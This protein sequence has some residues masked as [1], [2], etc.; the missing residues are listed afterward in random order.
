MPR[1]LTLAL[2]S[3]SALFAQTSIQSTITGTV[4]DATSAVVEGA[5]VIATRDSTGAVYEAVSSPEGVYLLPRVA[6]GV[7]SVSAEK[8]GF[9]RLIRD[10]I[11]VS[12]NQTAVVDLNLTVG[13][14]AERVQV[15]ADAATVQSQTSEVSLL[16]GRRDVR[17][18]PLNGKDFQ[19]LMFLAPGVGGQRATNT[20]TNNS[21]SGAR[22]GSNNY[23]IDGVSANDER[24]V[25]G[26]PLGASSR[27]LPNVI[28]TEA[29]EEFR[30]ITSNADAT[31]GRG[32]GGQ[33]NGITRSGSNEFHGS[34]YEFL[35]NDALD[36]RDF[37][38]YGPFFDSQ[39]RSVTPPFRQ[40]LFGGTIGGPVV[41][42]K[43]FFFGNYEGFRQRLE[44]SSNVNLP[45]ADLVRL[46]PGQF[47]Q[48]AR[49]Y[50]FE[51][52]L[53]PTSG[54]LPGELRPFGQ[55]DRQAAIAGGF[56]PVLFDANVA[57]GEAATTLTS[58]SSTADFRQNAFLIRTD[59]VFTDKLHVSARYA[60]AT[61]RSDANTAGLPGTGT[62]TPASFHSPMVQTVYTAAPNQVL[63]FRA[64]VMRVASDVDFFGGFPPSVA[65]VGVSPEVGIQVSAAGTTF[66][67][68]SLAP[69]LVRDNQ[70]TPQIAAQHTLSQGRFTLR[71]G[72]DIRHINVNF[73]NNTFPRP[74]WQFAGLVGPN[75]LLGPSSSAAEAVAVS[76]GQTFFG[77]NNGPTTPQRG[78][79]S[80]QQEYFT[81]FDWRVMRNLTLNLGIRY[82]YFG[83]YGEANDALSNLYAEQDGRVVPDINAFT[84][85]RLANTVAPISGDL[86]LY[87]PDRNNWQPR[88]GFAWSPMGRTV[89]RGAYG[90]YVDRIYQLPLSNLA[91]NVPYAIAASAANVSF[92][93]GDLP[94]SPSQRPALFGVDPA[95]RNPYLHRFNAAVE[96]EVF[97]NTT[98]TAAYVGSIGRKLIRTDEPNMAG[99]FPLNLRPEQRFADQRIIANLSSSDYDSLQLTLRRRFAAGLSASVTYTWSSYRDDSST[100]F[101]PA[102]P[103]L[104]NLDASSAAGFQGG[105]RLAPRPVTADYGRSE[106]DAPHVFVAGWVYDLPFGKSRRWGANWNGIVDG[107]LGNWSVSG[108]FQIRS[109]PPFEVT[110][111]Q[112]VNDDGYFDDRPALTGGSVTDL[113]THND[114]GTQFLL[115]QAEARQR[116]VVP[117]DV[118][119]PFATISR[120]ALRGDQMEILDFSLMKR[121]ALKERVTL[122]VEANVFNALNHAN[123]AV[124]N[125]NLSSPFFGQVTGTLRTTTPRQI[126]LGVRLIF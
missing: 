1:F 69:F 112:D 97:N 81:Q 44:L 88:L 93:T 62:S 2:V 39:G 100:D 9:R 57:N 48:L 27:Q 29:L 67:L 74:T 19:K 15:T 123:F 126:Q 103:T 70:T 12:V 38:N 55:A 104:I 89:I 8:Q 121:I 17:D 82:S 5:K 117:S 106:N 86:R 7:Y 96:Q 58:R 79:R 32:S 107:L 63:E 47:G 77:T 46:F 36:A 109:G 52:G 85:G 53:V 90:L 14:V 22:E 72:L 4:R 54:N 78:W 59:H 113:Y 21:V 20:N 105:T 125:A 120:N 16:V 73:R 23:V 45:N 18:L 118:T 91:N 33:I 108:L 110:L 124:P 28:S 64:G 83:V 10:G 13:D 56:N 40:N 35:R 99:G 37:F 30:V 84:F 26:L 92:S 115:T 66:L 51:T 122:G 94:L 65:A 75:G 6:S 34:A 116:L 24:Q 98:V 101:F 49:A 42:N 111:G 119:N 41:R 50:Y 11:A 68:P 71:T 95:L 61:N 114:Q 80:L 87:K 3:W 25:A 60:N 43:H 31:F 102:R 76:V